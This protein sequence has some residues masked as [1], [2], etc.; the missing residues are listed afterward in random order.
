MEN[1]PRRIPGAR[2]LERRVQRHG[3]R[4]RLAAAVIAV[5]WLIAIVVF[6]IVERLVDPD[7]FD[8]VWLGMWWATQTVTTVGY[9]DVVPQDTAGKVIATLLM[10]G[11]LSL[12]AVITGVITSVFVARAQADRRW[13]KGDP[14][15]GKLEQISGEL[16]EMR[17]EVARLAGDGGARPPPGGIAQA[18][19]VSGAVRPPAVPRSGPA[20]AGSDPAPVGASSALALARSAEIR[21]IAAVNGA[22]RISPMAPNRAPPAIVTIRTASGCMPSAVPIANGWTSCWRMLLASS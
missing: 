13:T 7:T 12:F 8:N 18:P 19:A 17:A 11:G 20:A 14:V 1:E 10:V 15:M 2:F 22:A 3:L 6:G 5:V 21:V 4:P 16:D 9:G